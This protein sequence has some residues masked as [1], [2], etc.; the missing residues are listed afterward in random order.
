V[1]RRA[2]RDTGGPNG[3][4]TVNDVLVGHVG[5]ERTSFQLGHLH[6]ELPIGVQQLTRT[7]LA[8][9][10][11]LPEELTNAIGVVLDHLDD[12]LREMPGAS[13]ADV[14][15][16]GPEMQAIAAIE[17]GGPPTFPFR[18]GHDAAEDVF[19]TVVT[20]R[21][22]ERRRNPGLPD[23]LV[24]TIVGGACVL[25]AVMRRL[26]LDSLLID[27]DNSAGSSAGSGPT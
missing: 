16:T 5:T 18:I 23:H 9:D 22:S 14:R 27:D 12:L 24:Y 25:V 3:C 13:S 8:T 19:R 26:R 11:P 7:E 17:V 6:T 15:L 20:E 2:T 4:Q 1:G 21:T 10:P